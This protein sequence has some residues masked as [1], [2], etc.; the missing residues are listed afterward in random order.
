MFECEDWGKG[1]QRGSC[2]YADFLSNRR[3]GVAKTYKERHIRAFEADCYK[4]LAAYGYMPNEPV[5]YVK[6]E[7][8]SE[9]SGGSRE[10]TP[11]AIHRATPTKKTKPRLRSYRQYNKEGKKEC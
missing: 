9:D 5:F 7:E 3:C 2:R 10:Q 11:E 6:K 4:K 8:H 1:K